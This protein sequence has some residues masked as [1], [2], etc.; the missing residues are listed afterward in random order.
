MISQRSVDPLPLLRRGQSERLKKK[1][2]KRAVRR[3][4]LLALALWGAGMIAGAAFAGRH[5]LRNSARFNLRD[6]DIAPTTR[7]PR[8]ELHRIAARHAGS[9]LF[10]LDVA[11]IAADLETIRWVRAAVVKRV[12][13]DRLHC[14][15]E[16]RTPRG[17]ARLGDRVWLID[18]EGPID[19]YG[20]ETQVYSFPILTGVSGSDTEQ[21][22]DQIRRG[23]ALLDYLEQVDPHLPAQIS[24]IDLERS[25][26]IGLYMA[27]GGPEVRIHPTDFDS[28]LERYLTMREYLAT[29]FGD[30]AYVDLRFRDR[31]SFLPAISRGQ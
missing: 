3:I 19:L 8:D 25:D 15:I 11:G 10:R 1:R 29:H 14:A 20:E 22:R 13:P 12:F 5:Y 23:V 7:A 17:L 16:E 27:A 6:I 4:V 30:G 18:A 9:N 21:Q 24:E 26:R 31:I 28:N 2:R